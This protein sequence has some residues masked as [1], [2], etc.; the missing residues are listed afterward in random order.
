MKFE[1][2]SAPE[3]Q[4]ED[5]SHPRFVLPF[6]RE[7][8]A[9]FKKHQREFVEQRGLRPWLWWRSD[10]APKSPSPPPAKD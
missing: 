4:Y 2:P 1:R 3:P 10:F 9:K 7:A 8:F 5:V 6:E